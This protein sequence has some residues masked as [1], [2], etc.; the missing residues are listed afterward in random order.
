VR[1]A[2]GRRALRVAGVSAGAVFLLG[3][4]YVMIFEDSLIYFPAVGGV[5]AAPGEDV[6]LTTSDGVRIHGW[7]RRNPAAKAAILYF[8]GNGGNL[9]DRR[10][11]I[12][13]LSDLPADV[14]A[15]DYRGYGK[16]GGKPSEAGLYADAA[17]A[18]DWLAAKT[19]PS[20]IVLLGKS[21]GAAPAIELASTRAVGGLVVQSA[22]TSAPD[23]SRIVMPFFPARWFMRHRYDNLAKIPKAACPKLIVHSRDDEMIPFA[24]AERLFAAAGEP[25]EAAWFS[26]AGHNDLWITHRKEYLE[27]LR[28]FLGRTAGR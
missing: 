27:R 1:T 15:V 4:G 28:A 19:D 11:F 17:A 7:Y 26:G 6:F 12:G 2:L 20:R 9:E 5:G 3:L 23:M 22:F 16:S 25:R 14:L 18:W 21:L 8:H 13:D 10:D 24:M